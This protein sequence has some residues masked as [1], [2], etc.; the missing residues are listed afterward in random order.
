MKISL[1]QINTTVGDFDGNIEKIALYTK[2]SD[3][4][5]L[6]VF[7]ELTICGYPVFD[8]ASHE[9]FVMA[10]E[11]A[12]GRL[13]TMLP[14]DKAVIV[15][16]L[17]SN[18]TS[19]PYNA[20]AF[21][22]NRQ[23]E[24][25]QHK[26]L[27]PTYDV[28]DEQRIFSSASKQDVFY[29]KGKRIGLCIC[30][31]IWNNKRYLE[32]QHSASNYS[33]DPVAMLVR[34][35][36]ELI[37]NIS[38]SPFWVDKWRTR[39]QL[40]KNVASEH[41]ITVCYTNLVGGNDSLLFDG[42]SI[43]ITPDGAV[44]GEGPTFREGIVNFETDDD[45]GAR[46]YCDSSVETQ[47]H[48]AIVLGIRDYVRKTGFENVVIGLSGG[49][50]SAVT[51][52]LAVKAIGNEHVVGV[53]MPSK[54]SSD[55]SKDDA[56]KLARNLG[57]RYLTIPIESIKKEYDDSFSP[58]QTNSLADQNIQA[59]I[60][61][62]ILMWLSN[63]E[64]KTIVLGTSNKSE[65]SV[66]YC[67]LYGDMAA[68]FCPLADV[69]KTNVYKLAEYINNLCEV[70]PCNTISKAPSAELADGQVDTDSLPPYEVLD[71]IL[72]DYIEER[73]P[74]E[75]IVV[76]T[77]YDMKTISRIVRMVDKNEFK[78]RQA[79]PTLKVTKTAFG[80]GRRLPIARKI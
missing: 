63:S 70:I 30:E 22:R 1:C 76:D 56:F 74:P 35:G 69:Y 4:A 75:Q 7:P 66:G 53:S 61:G 36:A 45:I 49:I 47:L 29:Y 20:A 72:Y 15:G 40:L 19:K 67:T 26:M 68:G 65:A 44:A 23:I 31:D 62:N 41:N 58:L 11:K 71:A 2:L 60:R 24:F 6:V 14:P 28:F 32:S 50:D 59:R 27:L 78:R 13:A 80:D 3:G 16:F 52:V 42:H 39:E 12:L 9:W 46:I 54:F 79:P 8:L 25:I 5:D 38:A 51:A 18:G 55:G 64:P 17:A 77:G 43:I 73:K 48:D 57:I 34:K 21:I 10:T 37:V 33:V